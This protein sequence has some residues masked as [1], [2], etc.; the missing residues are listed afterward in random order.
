MSGRD[1]EFAKLVRRDGN[2]APD[3][4]L[5]PLQGALW[6]KL[7]LKKQQLFPVEVGEGEGGGG[8]AMSMSQ[9]CSGRCCPGGAGCCQLAGLVLS[10]HLSAAEGNKNEAVVD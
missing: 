5:S 7:Q 2:I 6:R 3:D 1:E 9:S 8:S 10:A 4:Y